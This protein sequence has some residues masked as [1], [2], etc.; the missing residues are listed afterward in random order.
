MIRSLLTLLCFAVLAT[1][2]FAQD[3]HN[4]AA[5]FVQ[6]YAIVTATGGVSPFGVPGGLVAFETFGWRSQVPA[7]RASVLPATMT[8][9]TV[10][11][12]SAGIRLGRN[13]GVAI[14][15]PGTT[16]AVITMTLRR[17]DGS[18]TSEKSIEIPARQQVARFISDFFADVPEVPRDFDGTLTL[19]SNTPVAI[20]ALR[21][22]GTK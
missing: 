15:N 21:F 19:T 14:T 11:F 8:T 4:D 13:V 22:T 7:L 6:G 2:A 9:R 10:L 17:E 12:A 5:P 3:D 18:M 16:N 1:T 20:V